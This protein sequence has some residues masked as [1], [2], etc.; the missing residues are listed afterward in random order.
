MET[1]DCNRNAIATGSMVMIAG[2]GAIGVI[3][4]IHGG[5]ETAEQ[6]HRADHIGIDG[7][8]D[9][10]YPLNLIRPGFR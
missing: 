8:E 7:C 4:V 2:D 1:Y 6:L 9:R 3:K 5:G 10:F